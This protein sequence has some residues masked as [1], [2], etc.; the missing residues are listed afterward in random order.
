MQRCTHVLRREND[1]RPFRVVLHGLRYFCESL[2]AALESPG[3]DIQHRG[4]NSLSLL[5]GLARQVYRSDLLFVWGARISMGRVLWLARFLRKKNI[6]MY[7]CG[8]DVL[9]AQIQ[10]AEGKLSPW[11]A[12]KIH[13]A[14]APWLAEEVQALGLPCEYVPVTWVPLQN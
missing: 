6:V 14:G 13:W 10:H 3:W 4:V 8:S 9:G 1:K 11:I 5:L 7:W 2:P 12:K